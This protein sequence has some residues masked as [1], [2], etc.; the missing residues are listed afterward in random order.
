MFIL[1]GICQFFRVL[2]TP[3]FRQVL[4]E[5]SNP[6]GSMYDIYNIIY[7]YVPTNLP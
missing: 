6:I 2:V 7:I 4:A 3:M 5:F 1:M